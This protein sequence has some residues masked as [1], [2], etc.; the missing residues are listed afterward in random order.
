MLTGPKSLKLI[1]QYY[2]IK[3]DIGNLACEFIVAKLACVSEH[4]D[5]EYSPHDPYI[6]H[7]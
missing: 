7:I 5:P 3:A 6:S 4:Q 2:L 1:L